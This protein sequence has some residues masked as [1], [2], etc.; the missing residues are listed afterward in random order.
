AG[1]GGGELA[2]NDIAIIQGIV[3]VGIVVAA[4]GYA[5][6]FPLIGG[7][8]AWV[9]GAGRKSN[10][11]A[12]ANI[13]GGRCNRYS[14]DL[15][16]IYRYGYVIASMGVWNGAGG[17]GGD[18]AID[19]IAG[20]YCIVGV[21]ECVSAYVD[22]ILLPLVYGSCSCIGGRCGEGDGCAGADG[23]GGWGDGDGRGCAG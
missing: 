17:I 6:L 1:I 15:C 8:G 10:G 11:C 5:I 22:T 19:D 21:G 3:G 7:R 14:G 18:E 16:G 20:G 23:G 12:G 9:G 13:V 2:S 4:N